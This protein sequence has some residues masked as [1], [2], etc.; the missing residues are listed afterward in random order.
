M[1]IAPLLGLGLSEA[2]TLD[3]SQRRYTTTTRQMTP[4]EEL[5]GE[6]GWP[7]CGAGKLKT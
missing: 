7:A 6:T 3:A 5:S 1:G 2:I 4:D